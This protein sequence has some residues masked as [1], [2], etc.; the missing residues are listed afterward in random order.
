MELQ[1]PFLLLTPG[2]KLLPSGHAAVIRCGMENVVGKVVYASLSIVI[3]CAD[4]R[5]RN[6]FFPLIIYCYVR[7][8][9]CYA[10]LFLSVTF[11][12]LRFS[13]HYTGNRPAARAAFPSTASHRLRLAGATEVECIAPLGHFRSPQCSTAA[14]P[15]RGRARGKYAGFATPSAFPIAPSAGNDSRVSHC[16]TQQLRFCIRALKCSTFNH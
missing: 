12:T 1:S 2:L 4:K 14:C 8:T 13:G 5:L 9:G 7:N 15:E 11:H 10:A 16:C 3:R 6:T